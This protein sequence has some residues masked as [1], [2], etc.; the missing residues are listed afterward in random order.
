MVERRGTAGGGN[1]AATAMKT[2]RQGLQCIERVIIFAFGCLCYKFHN[3]YPELRASELVTL[4]C[5]VMSGSR[6]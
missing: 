6:R 1:G 3:F 2:R 5:P 4:R